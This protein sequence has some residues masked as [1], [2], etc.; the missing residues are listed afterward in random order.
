MPT[1]RYTT[2]ASDPPATLDAPDRASAL[3]DLAARGVVPASVEQLTERAARAALSAQSGPA[4]SGLV[5]PGSDQL[6]SDRA[7]PAQAGAGARA[8]AQPGRARGRVM[9]LPETASFIR[10][11]ATALQAG[12]PL[13]PALRTLGKAGRTPKQIA[14]LGHLIAQVE[15]GASLAEACRSWG[16]PFDELIISLV[17]AGEAS[18]KIADVLHQA[19]DLLEKRLALRDSIRSATLYPA[20]LLVLVSIAI[21]VVTTVIVPQVL[22]PLAKQ[23]IPLPLPT[24]IVKGVADGFAS[25]WWALAALAACAVFVWARLRAAPASRLAIDRASLRLPLF[26]PLVRD[27]A[28]A[29]FVRT[30]GTLVRSGLPVLQALKLT[31]GTLGNTAMRRAVEGVCDQVQGGKT[32]AGPLEA[33]GIFPPL[34]VQIV[35]LGERS[36]KLSELLGQ[37]AGALERRAQTRVQTITTVLPPLLIVVLASAVGCVVAA[38]ILPLLSLQEAIGGAG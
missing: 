33:T 25:Y 28:V 29:R 17:R 7:G 5:Q 3:R 37:A 16:R 11:L 32:I 30:L 4:Q 26:G 13:V 34:L 15:Q 23:G 9:S 20:I 6:G 12:L 22:G 8:S 31:S 1:F 38:I 10:E 36:G 19:A 2:L 35:A 27:A 14:M 21:A 18:G 24:R